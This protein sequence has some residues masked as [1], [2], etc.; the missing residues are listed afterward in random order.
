MVALVDGRRLVPR[1]DAVL[2][3]PRL[4]AAA[5]RLGCELVLTAVRQ[6]QEQ[7]RSGSITAAAGAC[8]TA[9]WSRRSPG[10]RS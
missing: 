5:Q 1:T 3:D 2:A 7:A 4:A 9:A 8:P 10:R 6:A